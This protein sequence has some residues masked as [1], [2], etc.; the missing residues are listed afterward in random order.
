MGPSLFFT[1]YPPLHHTSPHYTNSSA[2]L[3]KCRIW[4]NIRYYPLT[5][6]C[7]SWAC[8]RGNPLREESRLNRKQNTVCLLCPL[9]LIIKME[10]AQEPPHRSNPGWRTGLCSLI[11]DYLCVSKWADSDRRWVN[12]CVLGIKMHL[13]GWP[14]QWLSHRDENKRA[15]RVEG[16]ANWFTHWNTKYKLWRL[17]HPRFMRFII[18]HRVIRMHVKACLSALSGDNKLVSL[19]ACCTEHK[20]CDQPFIYI[21]RCVN[22]EGCLAQS[23]L[24]SLQWCTERNWCRFGNISIQFNM[25]VQKGSDMI[26]ITSYLDETCDNESVPKCCWSVTKHSDT[27]SWC[28]QELLLNSCDVSP[29][30]AAPTEDTA[31]TSSFLCEFGGF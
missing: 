15:W 6:L 29:R 21:Q 9:L 8:V 14:T 28:E 11:Y 17:R 5:A 26:I 3:P 1:A 27:L 18:N 24:S 20:V 19:E 13:Q 30:A 22:V 12:R 10:F 16:D 31:V 2:E 23:T 7:N 4:G 25:Y